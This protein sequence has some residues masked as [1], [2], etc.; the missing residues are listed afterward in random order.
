MLVELYHTALSRVLF[1]HD[2]CHDNMVH[3]V[4]RGLMC[5]G[6]CA[7]YNMGMSHKPRCCMVDLVNLS[8]ADIKVMKD[9]TPY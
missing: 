5:N 9:V 3:D 2:G 6:S 4:L 7:G 1:Q 8:C